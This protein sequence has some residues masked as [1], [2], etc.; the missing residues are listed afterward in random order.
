MKKPT[1][2]TM[3]EAH[4]QGKH[5]AEMLAELQGG[6][7]PFGRLPNRPEWLALCLLNPHKFRSAE[8]ANWLSGVSNVASNVHG[9]EMPLVLDI[10][11]VYEIAE[12]L[13][14]LPHDVLETHMGRCKCGGKSVRVDLLTGPAI[15]CPICRA[16]A[17][18]EAQSLFVFSE[19]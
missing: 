14:C 15:A 7:G 12:A 3:I 2:R 9:G 4:N 16:L 18:N 1:I 10:T 11:R 19:G 13:K 6:K 17:L 8:W 5:A